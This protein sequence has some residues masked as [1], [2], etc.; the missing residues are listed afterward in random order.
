MIFMSAGYGW[1]RR[2]L[3]L[4][5]VTDTLFGSPFVHPPA[6]SASLGPAVLTLCCDVSYLSR[7]GGDARKGHPMA[8][9]DAFM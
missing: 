1:R 9:R 5:I 7:G 3:L 2:A 4:V 8:T 6:S